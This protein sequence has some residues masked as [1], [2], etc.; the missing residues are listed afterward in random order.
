MPKDTSS[1]LVVGISFYHFISFCKSCQLLGL[2]CSRERLEVVED[3]S[4]HMR[5]DMV[6]KK[7]KDNIRELNPLVS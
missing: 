7:E 5:R 3:D 1:N 2:I 4:R 6:V